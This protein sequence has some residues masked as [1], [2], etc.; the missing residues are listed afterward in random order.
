[1]PLQRDWRFTGRTSQAQYSSQVRRH[2]CSK[3]RLYCCNTSSNPGRRKISSRL[4]RLKTMTWLHTALLGRPHNLL[5]ISMKLYCCLVPVTLFPSRQLSVCVSRYCAA[6]RRRHAAHPGVQVVISA[7]RGGRT[8]HALH[9]APQPALHFLGRCGGLQLPA[10]PW[11]GQ[12]PGAAG[13]RCGGGRA[14]HRRCQRRQLHNPRRLV[15]PSAEN[16]ACRSSSTRCS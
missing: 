3:L 11:L 6:A 9:A 14:G 4:C 13:G 1:M 16:R 15:V 7:Q 10:E 5:R 12:R 2:E 8:A